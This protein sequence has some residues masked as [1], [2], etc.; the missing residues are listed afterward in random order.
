M[1]LSSPELTAGETLTVSVTLKNTGNV[2]G[3]EVLQLYLQDVTA[4]VV[5][6]V[7]ELKGIRRITLDPGQETEVSFVVDEPMLRFLKEN[8]TVE[9]EA[10]LFRVWIGDSSA[11][12][13]A[14]EFV[15]K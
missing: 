4:S 2:S 13:N 9:S 1:T 11:T 14:A 8:G 5:R 15:L 10:G 12:E 3:T 6:P 7:K